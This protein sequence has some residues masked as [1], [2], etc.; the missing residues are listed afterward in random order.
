MR[1]G[2]LR[3]ARTMFEKGLEIE[4]DDYRLLDAM[5]QLEAVDGNQKKAIE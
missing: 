4:P 2:R 5:A 1:N 3:G